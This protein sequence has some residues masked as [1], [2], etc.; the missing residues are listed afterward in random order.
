VPASTTAVFIYAQPLIAAVAS[1]LAFDE[2][3]SAG[4]LI[5]TACLFGGIWL[6]TRKPETVEAPEAV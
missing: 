2:R 5:A 1:W 4:M 6:V 3:P